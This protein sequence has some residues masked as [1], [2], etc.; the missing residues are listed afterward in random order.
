VVID[1]PI[2]AR[3]IAA[4]TCKGWSICLSW[5]SVADERQSRFL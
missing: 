3:Y 2:R 4:P 1:A 5:Q